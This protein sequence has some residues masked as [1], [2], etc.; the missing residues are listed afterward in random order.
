MNTWDFPEIVDSTMVCKNIGFL[1]D[2]RFIYNQNNFNKACSQIDRIIIMVAMKF[3]PN[4]WMLY[5]YNYNCGI[6]KYR[7][8]V[9][10]I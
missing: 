7:G 6:I 2:T 9:I 4:C 5:S 10:I 8:I 1:E 3:Y